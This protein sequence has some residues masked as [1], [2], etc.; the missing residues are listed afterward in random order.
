MPAPRNVTKPHSR[1]HR[2]GAR[3]P[4]IE[5]P[6]AGCTLP[7]PDMPPGREWT[8]ADRDRWQELW[9]SPQAVMW[10][11]SARGTVAILV[12]YEAAILAG[13]ASAWMAQEARYAG[14][15]L[16]LTPRA[17]AALG[18]RITDQGAER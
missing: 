4:I 15:A 18:W 10:D 16:G 8:D 13:N 12:V 5:L 1:A 6:A 2:S 14:E 17:M 3:A 11:D 7:V 9:K